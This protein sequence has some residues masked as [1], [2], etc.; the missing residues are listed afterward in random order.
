MHA[1]LREADEV[2]WDTATSWGEAF[3]SLT[4]GTAAIWL[5]ALGSKPLLGHDKTGALRAVATYIERVNTL[6]KELVHDKP[7]HVP[8]PLDALVAEARA[9]PDHA[10][11]VAG[12]MPRYL[13]V[14]GRHGSFPVVLIGSAWSHTH[15][16]PRELRALWSDGGELERDLIVWN[17][18]RRN[19]VITEGKILRL[20]SE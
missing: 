9:L 18:S 16:N 7:D 11:Q 14:K 3:A 19:P 10:N 8:P 17:P 1:L 20:P 13:R 6:M 5:A 2:R 12:E 15:P 4:L